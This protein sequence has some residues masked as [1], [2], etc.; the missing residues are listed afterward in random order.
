MSQF[1]RLRSMGIHALP[2]PTNPSWKQS[3]V[4]YIC[5]LT[6]LSSFCRNQ[7]LEY[8]EPRDKLFRICKIVLIWAK[9]KTIMLK[10]LVKLINSHYP[11]KA[12]PYVSKRRHR[13]GKHIHGWKW[14][15]ER[16]REARKILVEKYGWHIAL[17]TNYISILLNRRTVGQQN[18]DN[19][20]E[21]CSGKYF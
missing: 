8:S 11:L 19:D 15:V 12:Y 13:C 21:K 3:I 17:T 7:F 1:G 10:Q 4:K 14:T 2:N 18:V 9:I 20:Q 16:L 6:I 5:C